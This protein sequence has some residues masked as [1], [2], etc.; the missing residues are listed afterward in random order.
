[1]MM[2]H[3][4]RMFI[5]NVKCMYTNWLSNIDESVK[6]NAN[7]IK[8]LIDVRNEVKCMNI[9]DMQNIICIIH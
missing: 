5:S 4:V 9:F 6:A 1:M 3:L 2:S 7:L 8:E